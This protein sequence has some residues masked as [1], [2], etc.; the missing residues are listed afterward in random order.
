MTALKRTLLIFSLT[1]LK[2]D[3]CI[4]KVW[5]N[6][7]YP[8]ECVCVCVF[9]STH[10]CKV[11][12]DKNLMDTPVYLQRKNKLSKELYGVQNAFYTLSH[13]WFSI[14]SLYV[15]VHVSFSVAACVCV[16]KLPNRSVYI[17]FISDYLWANF[18]MLNKWFLLPPE[19]GSKDFPPRG[20]CYYRNRRC[21][22]KLKCFNFSSLH[23]SKSCCH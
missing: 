10:H 21:T 20:L 2:I 19:D 7:V 3:F 23:K 9:L 17:P 4:L 14:E 6:F 22:Q 11:P 5:S 16:Y 13:N 12:V 18:C 15:C 1:K 8:C